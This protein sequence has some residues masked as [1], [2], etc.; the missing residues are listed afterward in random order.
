GR[1][2]PAPVS[3]PGVPRLLSL[4]LD[5]PEIVIDRPQAPHRLLVTG[6]YSDGSLR[7]L[8]GRARFTCSDRLVAAV[9]AA[10]LVTPARSGSAVVA[11]SVPGSSR[12]V[13]ATAPL[14]VRSWGE[15]Y[16]WDFRTQIAPLLTKAGCN[17]TGCHGSAVGKGGF[18]LSAFGHDPDGDYDALV[19][20]GG[21]R[22]VD[23]M[24][25]GRSLLLLK[26]TLALSHGGGGRF[27]VQSLPYRMLAAWIAAGAPRGGD[28]ARVERL[29]LFPR[30]RVLSRPGQRQRLLVL[31]H[32]SDGTR[33][34]VSDRALYEVKNEA[35]ATLDEASV[36]AAALGEA[37]IL[38]RYGG[39]VAA[40][41]VTTTPLPPLR[42]FPPYSTADPVDR[43]VFGKLKR[44]RLE[45][46][47]PASDWE[48]VRRVYLDLAGRIPSADEVERFVADI[49]PRKREGLADRLLGSTE[50]RRHWRDNLNARL[51]G[52]TAFPMA[53]EWA[54]WLDTALREDRGWDRMARELLVARPE[55]P[56]GL[57]AIRF[58]DQRLAQG[59]TGLDLVTRDVSRIFFGVDI[60]CAR[61]HT[62]PDVASWQQDVYWGIAAFFGRTYRLPVKGVHYL[63]ER[64]VG[65]VEYFGND[66]NKRPAVPLFLTGN[67]PRE[68]ALLASATA[69]GPAADA[70]ALYLVA[71]E[72]AAEKTRVPVPR[73]SRR[74]QFVELAVNR[75]NPYFARA[76]VNWAWALLMGRGLVEPI[77]QMHAGNP[78]SH[79]ALLA[80]LAEDFARHGYSIRHLVRRIVTSSAYGLSS[81]WTRGERPAADLFAV[82]ALRPQSMQQLAGS[83]VMAAGYGDAA[84]KNAGGADPSKGEPDPALLRDQIEAALAA[85]LAELSRKLDSGTEV[86]QADVSQ[87]LYLTNGR[88]F[89]GLVEKGGLAERLAGD[90]DDGAVVRQAYLA[91]LGRPPDTQEAAEFQR[92]LRARKERRLAALQGLV[93]ALVT[94]SEFRFIH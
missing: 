1:T 9:S 56:E 79:P 45:P 34:D 26:P 15:A 21:G 8:T 30:Q 35:A 2:R 88:S 59:D 91:V 82:A 17:G 42:S 46:A 18:R 6:R 36:R 61:C 60:Q 22:R 23:R 20:G 44:L 28:R 33:E 51:M 47:P 80:I 58:L 39:E 5:P 78:A 69:P 4:A 73:Y 54:A 38:A 13:R 27:R 52:R 11:A 90:P 84:R 81:E 70:P 43:E 66:K 71:P 74:G 7:D 62:H 49:D 50:F 24:R 68:P 67:R 41:T 14:R 12:E 89:Q 94:S 92:Y 77:D 57:P 83:L 55:K 65:E 10:G 72:E 29:E 25:P 64:A 87:A 32:Y 75:G 63:A 53:P 3:S 86:F 16:R 19:Y 85:Q 31:A 76:M 48:Y 40:A 37:V 93:W